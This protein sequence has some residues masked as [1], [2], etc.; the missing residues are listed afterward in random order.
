MRR[1][2]DGEEGMGWGGGHV[3]MPLDGH[4]QL[5]SVESQLALRWARHVLHTTME[6]M[7]VHVASM[8]SVG[9]FLPTPCSMFDVF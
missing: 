3:S 2:W 9:C 7:C 4:S 1:A 6:A 8:G 5:K